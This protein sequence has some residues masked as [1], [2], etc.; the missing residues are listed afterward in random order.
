M[1]QPYTTLLLALIILFQLT[2][3]S[4][5]PNNLDKI[6]TYA[7]EETETRLSQ[8]LQPFIEQ[9]P[10]N[11]AGFRL[12]GDN[13][14]AFSSRI[15]L[16]DS[17][18]KSI[19]AQ[20]Y[21]VEDQ[22]TG[23]LFLK[24][25]L[26]AADRGVRVRLLVDD[27]K[28][29]KRDAMFA[30]LDS[31]P[32][33]SVRAFNPFAFRTFSSLNFL[34]EFPRLDRR[35]HNKSFNVDNIISIVGGRNIGDKYFSASNELEFKDLDV[36]CVGHN[37]SNQVSTVFDSYW[38]DPY[39]YPFMKLH[40]PEANDLS[41]NEI[42]ETFNLY[43]EQEKNNIYTQHAKN[44]NIIK[45][46]KSGEVKLAWGEGKIYSD[47]PKQARTPRKENSYS[48]SPQILALANE[49]QEDILIISPYFI[50]QYWGEDVFGAWRKRG[51]RVRVITNSLASN[52][53]QSVHAE[54]AKYRKK[55]LKMG[56]EL[57][58]LKPNHSSNTSG[59]KSKVSGLHA[60]SFI[61][62]KRRIFI[63]SMNLD[64]RSIVLNTEMGI[65]IKNIALSKE[66]NDWVD[67]NINDFAYKVELKQEDGM[68]Q[69]EWIEKTSDGQ[70]IVYH[71]EP[72][73]G[74]LKRMGIDFLKILPIEGEF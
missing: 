29:D 26:D 71:H 38:N 23:K 37:I 34:T 47:S 60:K 42:R 67:N 9:H 70:T 45:Q 13:L 12:L 4:H 27:L 24:H 17:A 57:Y 41:L 52:D 50:P 1:K 39:A 3:C 61:F 74:L 54:Y 10:S 58:E 55:L 44:S 72:Q 21:A 6:K 14:D 33:M 69:L 64:P 56:V 31:H 11:E 63:G 16:I 73:I 51:I 5:L 59:I 25:L 15:I 46:L 40:Q 48:M 36:L 43:N 65:L 8:D 19:D 32:Y 22:L 62:D 68:E 30:S 53:V 28:T 18:E 66:L 35:M 7:F 20:Y 49:S 2:A